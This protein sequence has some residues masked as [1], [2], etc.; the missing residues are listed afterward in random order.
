MAEDA[1]LTLTLLRGGSRISYE[2]RAYAYTEAPDDVRSLLKQR[3]RW[4]YGTLQCLW[5]HR[6]A[7]FNRRQ[8]SLGFIAMPS[9][10]LFQ[11]LYSML[12]PVIDL[13]FVFSLFSGGSRLSTL[14]Y[15]VFFLL[16]LLVAY[17]AFRLEKTS[18]KP[19]VWLFLQRIVYRQLMTYVIIKSIVAAF[20]GA[21]VG[22]NKL[23][24]SGSAQMSREL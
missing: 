21:A 22:W 24:R 7:L 17:H 13:L 16:D 20:R 8:R 19:L 18:A 1:D 9:M 14:Y 5:K 11:Y 2:E 15:A 4:T 10:W 23:K 6:G 3:Y 12:S